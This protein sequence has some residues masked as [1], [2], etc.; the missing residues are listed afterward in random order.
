MILQKKEL[1]KFDHHVFLKVT[2]F[3]DYNMTVNL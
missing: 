2:W 3:P 1:N